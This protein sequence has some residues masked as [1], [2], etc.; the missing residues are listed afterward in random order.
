MKINEEFVLQEIA[1]E[2][3]VVPIGKA[4]D[5]LR[6]VVKLNAAGIFLWK[7]MLNDDQS[8]ESLASS[9]AKKYAIS[10]EKAQIDVERFLLKLKKI[11]CIKV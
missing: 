9:L 8:E 6:G 1:D 3:I 2:G 10:Y 11:G 5:S 4:A 7:M